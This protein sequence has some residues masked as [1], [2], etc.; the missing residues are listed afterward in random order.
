M[1]GRLWHVVCNACVEWVW[2]KGSYQLDDFSRVHYASLVAWRIVPKKTSWPCHWS[3]T[4]SG[5]SRQ[6]PISNESWRSW[7][8]LKFNL[9]N[10]LQKD[11]SNLASHHTG[12]PSSLCTKRMGRWGCVWIIELSTRWRWK[13]NTHYLELMIYLINSQELNFLIGLTFV[14]GI[15]KFG[16]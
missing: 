6:G 16:F 7:K 13:I 11:T 5:T 4:G 12:H 8:N 3:D 1:H 14:Q 9:K 10:S 2:I 15:T